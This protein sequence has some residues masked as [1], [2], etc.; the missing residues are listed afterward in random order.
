[1]ASLSTVSFSYSIPR[2]R[3]IIVQLNNYTTAAIA[4][5]DNNDRRHNDNNDCDN[6]D[7]DD[8]VDDNDDNDDDD[9]DDNDDDD[10]DNDKVWPLNG[11]DGGLTA[12]RPRRVSA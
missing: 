8:D 2:V 1:M 12:R 3:R 11:S 10:N 4:A 7:N 9:N 5:N 6:D